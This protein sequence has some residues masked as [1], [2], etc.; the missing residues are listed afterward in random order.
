LKAIVDF[1]GMN[2]SS[3]MPSQSQNTVALIFPSDMKFAVLEMA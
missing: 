2:S 1:C 3:S